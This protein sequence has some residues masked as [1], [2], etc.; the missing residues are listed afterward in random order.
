MVDIENS[1]EE[2]SSTNQ[3]ATALVKRCMRVYGWSLEKSR[4]VL[5]AYRQFLTLKKEHEDT[6][7]QQNSLLVSGS[8]NVA[9]AYFRCELL[10]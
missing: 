3:G 6:G 4:K 10:S 2:D 5:K 7:V 8:I 9:S 1:D